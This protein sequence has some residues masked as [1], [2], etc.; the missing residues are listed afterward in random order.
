MIC[1]NEE[2]NKT[3]ASY[4]LHSTCFECTTDFRDGVPCEPPTVCPICTDAFTNDE[5][6]RKAMVKGKRDRATAKKKAKRPRK[7]FLETDSE[8]NTSPH[9][10]PAKS[11]YSLRLAMGFYLRL[12]HT[13]VACIYLP[14]FSSLQL[15][16]PS[17]GQRALSRSWRRYRRQRRRG[18]VKRTRCGNC[19]YKLS[20]PQQKDRRTNLL[21]SSQN[22]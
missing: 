19:S 5:A 21:S 9:P 11:T 17:A 15:S 6:F 16:T 8:S 3:V 18:S 1:S 2:C 13:I 12:R 20:T 7:S 4:S 10:S 22:G 14:F